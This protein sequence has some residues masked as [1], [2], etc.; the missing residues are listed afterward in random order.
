MCIQ[1]AGHPPKHVKWFGVGV[2]GIENGQVVETWREVD[3]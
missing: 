3:P 1:H 2:N